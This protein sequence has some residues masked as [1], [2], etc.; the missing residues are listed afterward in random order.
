[1]S[2]SPSS[3]VLIRP[4]R[5]G[6]Y[7]CYLRLFPAL[8]V[9]EAPPDES[10]WQ[11]GYMPRALFLTEVPDTG[12]GGDSAEP[13]AYAYY[14]LMPGCGYVRNIMVAAAHR[15]RGHGRALMNA[16]A[17]LFRAAGCTEWRL[18]VLRDNHAAIALYRHCGMDVAYEATA[19]HLPFAVTADMPAASASVRVRSLAAAADPAM[20]RQFAMPTGLLTSLRKR[21]GSLFWQ[22]VDESRSPVECLGV[23]RF[24][25]AM[26]G[27]FPIHVR[28]PSLVRPMIE[29]MRAATPDGVDSLMLTCEADPDLVAYLRERGA[30]VRMELFHMRS[31]L[32]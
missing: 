4:A 24:S 9:P 19:L 22:L 31:D 27:A 28:V 10:A 32:P 29:A 8:G 6:D 14:D 1:M 3:D 21:P 23:T 11:A 7:P 26:P 17:D 2:G 30:Q 20:E 13:V 25:P 15:R 12:S 18:N 5:P 16:M